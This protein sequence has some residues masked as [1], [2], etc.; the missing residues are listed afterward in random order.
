MLVASKA[1]SPL[2]EKYPAVMVEGGEWTSDGSKKMSTVRIILEVD[3][4]VVRRESWR[5]VMKIWRCENDDSYTASS[6]KTLN[7]LNRDP[8]LACASHVSA[9]W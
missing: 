2:T 8:L 9:S 7:F 6:I 1:G 3:W 4:V 5:R